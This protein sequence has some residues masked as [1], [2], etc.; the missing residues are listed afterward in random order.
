MI[1]REMPTEDDLAKVEWLALCAL[2]LRAR[3]RALSRDATSEL[4]D[5]TSQMDV[6]MVAIARL[7]TEAA[8]LDAEIAVILTALRAAR[9][10]GED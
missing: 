10:E 4:G 9:D 5:L 6:P 3:A 1:G 8:Q 7:E 2:N